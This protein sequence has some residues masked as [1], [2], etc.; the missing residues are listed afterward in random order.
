MRNNLI[1]S[2]SAKNPQFNRIIYEKMLTFHVSAKKVF[3]NKN[4]GKYFTF[5]KALHN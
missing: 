4:R 1:T 5:R 3:F 2:I